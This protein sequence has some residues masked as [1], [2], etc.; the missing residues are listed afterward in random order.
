MQMIFRISFRNVRNM[1]CMNNDKLT[2]F[3]PQVV[4]LIPEILKAA[5]VSLGTEQIK[6]GNLPL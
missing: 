5:S 4:K 2:L 6:P 1:A 3:F